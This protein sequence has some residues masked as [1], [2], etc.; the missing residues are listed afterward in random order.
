MEKALKKSKPNSSGKDLLGFYRISRNTV[1]PEIITDERFEEIFETVS[2][3][4]PLGIY[5]LQDD[6]LQHTNPQFQNLTGYSKAELLGKDL[7]L[8]VKAEDHDVVRSSIVLTL[9][10]KRS[11][12]SEYRISS[13][14]GKTNWVMQTVSAINY[15]GRE[16]ILGNLMDITER[17]YL[18]RKVIEY[19]ELSK[20][21]SDLLAT[22]SHELRTPLATIKGYSTMMLYYG[23]R[24]SGEENK[25]YLKSID[26]STDRLTRLVD[27]LLD[28][29]RME[30][31]L[32]KLQKYPTSITRL[33]RETAG[34][35]RVRANKHRITLMLPDRFPRID[36]DAKRIRQVLDNL[37]DNAFKYTPKETAIIISV[38]KGESEVV[39]SVIDHGPGI[40]FRELTR[41]FDRMYRI[42]ERLTASVDGIGLG[43]SIC[44]RLVEAHG[45]RIWAESEVGKGSTFSFTLPLTRQ[46]WKNT[47]T[48]LI[49]DKSIGA[50]HRK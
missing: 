6:R 7:M 1:V 49:V 45:G 48:K 10:E 24:L 50:H 18:E 42:E 13:K 38:Q 27:N 3:N 28:S 2:E 21:K 46:A 40:P 32:L 33:I 36:I 15:H 43:L 26:N 41:I 47:P 19:E 30:A 4:S 16:A 22:V 35:A 29:I 9:Q 34:E 5:I 8:F 23:D 39:V 14:N 17:K 12:P 20:L 25:E 11:F 37:L 44:R 31:G